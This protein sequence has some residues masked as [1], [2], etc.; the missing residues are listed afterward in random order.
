VAWLNQTEDVRR[1]AGQ[2]NQYVLRGQVDLHDYQWIQIWQDF[3]TY[4]RWRKSPERSRL[5][6]ERARFMTH[7]P[8]RSYDVLE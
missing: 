1:A 6:D 3:A 8:T 5:A 7:G 2:I 4:D